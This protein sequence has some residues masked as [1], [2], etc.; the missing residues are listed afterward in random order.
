MPR[1]VKNHLLQLFDEY[2][3]T[4][5]SV[6][7]GTKEVVEWA[8]A[9]GRLLPP[10]PRDP[11]QVL[12]DQMANALRQESYKDPQGREVRVNH[13]ARVFRHGT[14]F[15]V[16]DDVRVAAPKFMKKAFQQRRE[17]IVRD[18]LQLKT[19]VDSYNENQQPSNPIQLVLNFTEDVE[20][21]EAMEAPQ[22]PIKLTAMAVLN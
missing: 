8:V 4:F 5:N 18:C 14:Q 21:I 3:T 1:E 16:W 20:E 22:Q 12:A 9:T 17:Q 15:A 2:R 10:P 6:P 19:D 11:C 13:S 7:C